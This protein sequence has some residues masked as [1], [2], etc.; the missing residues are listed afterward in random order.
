M[1]KNI[2]NTQESFTRTKKKLKKILEEKGLVL[3]LCETSDIL[4]KALGY[5]NT[6][7]INKNYFEPLKKEAEEMLCSN[8][9]YTEKEKEDLMAIMKNSAGGKILSG[10]N[11]DGMSG[12]QKESPW[13]KGPVTFLTPSGKR[14]PYEPYELNELCELCKDPSKIIPATGFWD[15]GKYIIT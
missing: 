5:K 1:S 9:N 12:E 11:I 15:G 6:F 3:S 8:F 4:A 2:L 7:D 14:L 13:K 10:R